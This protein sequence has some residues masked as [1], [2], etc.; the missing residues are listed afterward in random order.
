MQSKKIVLI[1]IDDGELRVVGFEPT[2]KRMRDVQQ[3]TAVLDVIV[4]AHGI[5]A[6]DTFAYARRPAY[7]TNAF[8]D[9]AGHAA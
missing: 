3:A 5:W 8:G 1:D 4:G 6:R 2:G 9:G 7:P